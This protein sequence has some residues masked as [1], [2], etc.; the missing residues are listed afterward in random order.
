MYKTSKAPACIFR[1]SGFKTKKEAITELRRRN[2]DDTKFR[3]QT[4]LTNYLKE[5]AKLPKLPKA[6]RPDRLPPPERQ[7]V[8]IHGP[9]TV[10]G[11]IRREVPSASALVGLDLS[12]LFRNTIPQGSGAVEYVGEPEATEV[13]PSAVVQQM[14]Q[15]LPE[16]K[17]AEPAEE[18]ETE[19]SYYVMVK[20]GKEVKMTGA[21]YRDYLQE[22]VESKMEQASDEE[23]EQVEKEAIEDVE[24]RT[25]LE[26]TLGAEIEE[27]VKP[28][29]K[30]RRKKKQAE[31]L[32]VIKKE[33]NENMPYAD[34]LKE[35]YDSYKDF[36]QMRGELNKLLANMGI[37]KEQ[38][39]MRI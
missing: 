11:E 12:S 14:V 10:R 21:E 18:K 25:S 33:I 29:K 37:E 35:F 26:P 4:E 31:E 30:G 38:K 19:P 1:E 22:Y 2:V 23:L 17:E 32:K 36:K 34:G 9:K 8:R 6:P 20:P 3:N 24:S 5:I 39:C 13:A 15:D 27:E 28:K 16:E 7:K